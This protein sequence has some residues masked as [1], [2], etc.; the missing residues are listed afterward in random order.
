MSNLAL[1][2]LWFTVSIVF[3][4]GIGTLSYAQAIP[5][6]PPTPID[7]KKVELGGTPWNPEW[8][9]IIEQ[10]LP[11]EMLS[12]HV[13]QGVRR[14]CPRFF[15]MDTTDKRTFWAYFFHALAGAEAGL[16]PNTSVRHGEPEG[17]TVMRS[18]GLLQLAYADHNRYGCDFN[19]PLDRA[20]RP[21]DPAKTILQPK[22]NL[23]CG[24]KILVNQTIIQ[25]NPWLTPSGILVDV[26][27]DR[28]ELPRIRRA[29]DKSSRSMCSVHQIADLQVGYD[30]VGAGRREPGR[31]SQIAW[32]RLSNSRHTRDC[33]NSP[34]PA[35]TRIARGRCGF[36]CAY[37]SL[38][39][40][41]F[42]P[43]G[44]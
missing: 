30:E 16:N 41:T 37:S 4:I 12:S 17:A 43:L 11:P 28:A 33:R 1:K 18:E 14:F 3:C 44:K 26:A 20:L 5:P 22:N 42:R 38:N 21:N 19:W 9:Q 23:E 34:D 27:P 15:E 40:P 36:N 39:R 2:T 7:T 29:D 24:V 8:D 31:N 6:V 35:P 13:P 10:A 32:H 25:H